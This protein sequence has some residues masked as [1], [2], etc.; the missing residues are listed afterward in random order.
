[1]LCK[2]IHYSS[3]HLHPSTAPTHPPCSLAISSQQR[4]NW[5]GGTVVGPPRKPPPL[6]LLPHCVH[7]DLVLLSLLGEIVELH[8][9]LHRLL[10]QKLGNPLKALRKQSIPAASQN[11]GHSSFNYT[12]YTTKAES[13]TKPI[14]TTLDW[15]GRCM[16]IHMHC[17]H[18]SEVAW[19]ERCMKRKMESVLDMDFNYVCVALFVHV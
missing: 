5:C 1:M 16:Y 9:L 7:K 14:F 13:F 15:H 18:R 10:G 12:S 17:L 4:T 3:L 2:C 6:A 8:T 19:T 11:T